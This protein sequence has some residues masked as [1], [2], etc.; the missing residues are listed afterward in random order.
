[1]SNTVTS[2]VE[3][4]IW[5]ELAPYIRIEEYV[6]DR[7]HSKPRFRIEF[8]EIHDAPLRERVLALELPCPTCGELVN[9]IRERRV[10][11]G[12]NYVTQMYFAP[13]CPSIDSENCA[14]SPQARAAY[15]KVKEAVPAQQVLALSDKDGLLK[16]LAGYLAQ[17]T[18]SGYQDYV[19]RIERALI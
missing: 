18:P 4:P 3:A 15:Y 9:P 10:R 14:I 2:I 13:S 5:A 19:Q 6:K 17:V 8:R 12:K 16:E 1:M 11:N 7:G